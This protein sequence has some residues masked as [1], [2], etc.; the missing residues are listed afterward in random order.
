MN[1]IITM[2]GTYQRFKSFGN[3]IPKY[4]LALSSRT[5]LWHVIN[6][7]KAA[8]GSRNIYLIANE[9]DIDFYPILHSILNDNNIS[10]K[11]L[12]FIKETKSQLET[13]YLSIKDHLLLSLDA[14]KPIIFHNCDTLLLD[15]GEVFKKIK[16]L[17]ADESLVDTFKA[18]S[19]EYSYVMESKNNLNL[20][21]RIA[22]KIL[23]SEFACSGLYA[24]GSVDF[25]MESASK[26]LENDSKVNFTSLYQFILS[27]HKSIYSSSEADVSKT[28]VLGT[29]EDYLTNL[30]RFN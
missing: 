10:D 26:I 15:R 18:S 28:I 19:H 20:V 29:P 24:F 13:A 17:K 11:N 7:L 5:I 4:L 2:A 12:F 25:F 6:N 14:E 16:C 22:D 9:K 21:N 27:Q 23:L 1:I 8:S 3:K 30:R